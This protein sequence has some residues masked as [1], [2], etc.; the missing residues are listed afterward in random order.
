MRTTCLAM[1]AFFSLS[2]C[3]AQSPEAAPRQTSQASLLERSTPADGSTVAG[4]VNR[5]HLTFARP[6]RLLE[7]TL[8]GPDGL[9]PMMITAPAESIE[10]DVPLPGINAGSYRVNWRA[11]AA[12]RD[13]AGTL[14]F[15][16]RR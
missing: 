15:T 8:D 4:P 12:G 7:V 13:Y 10:Y 5:L 3:A 14:R 11:N 6:A 16:V 1:I 2:N 9:S